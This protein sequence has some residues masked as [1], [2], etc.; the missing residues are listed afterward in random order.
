MRINELTP[1]IGSEM[2]GLTYEELEQQ[3]VFDQFAEILHQRELVVVRGLELKPRQQLELAQRLGK[4]VPFLMGKYR[5]PDIPEIMISSNEVKNDKPIGVARVGNFW[6]QDSSYVD[7]PAPYTMLHGVN[8]P[9][10]SGHTL[11]ANAVD[12]YNRL[13]QEWKTKI[14]GRTALHTVNKRFRVRAEDAGLSIAE[15]RAKIDLEHPKVEHQLV[16][17]DPS[18]GLEYIYG[19][20]E[21]MDSVVG[22]DANENAAFFELLDELIQDPAKVYTHRWTPNDLV[23]WKTATTYHAATAVEPGVSRTVHRISIESGD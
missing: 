8:V 19:A 4:P 18:T 7:T 11:Y 17:Q 15:L 1:F 2:L 9:Q 3:E 14:A 23:V 13:P 5:H 12:V 6:H 10:T 21:Y 16:K 20:P 22:F